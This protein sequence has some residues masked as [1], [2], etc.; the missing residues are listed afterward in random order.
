[1]LDKFQIHQTPWLE[2]SSNPKNAK[3]FMDQNDYVF[4]RLLKWLFE[5]CLVPLVRCYFYVTE[6]AKEGTRVFY[7]RKPVWF[8][9]M[10]LAR[11]DL[12]RQ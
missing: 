5:D 8:L 6:K 11:E 12:L 2:F 1:M 4:W 10:K 7:F 9:F 3:Y